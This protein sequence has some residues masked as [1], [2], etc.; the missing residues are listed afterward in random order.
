VSE[1]NRLLADPNKNTDDTTIATVL[2][3]LALEEAELA[4]PRRKGDERRCSMRVND[5][6]LNGLRA[7]IGQRGGLAALGGNRCL[8]VFILM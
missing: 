3:L 4:D 6:H 1:V 7:M 5:V 8:Q 2:I